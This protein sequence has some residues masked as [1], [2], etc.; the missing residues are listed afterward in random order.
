MQQNIGAIDVHFT[1]A[2]LAELNS[3][4]AAIKINGQRLP[5][6]VQV[7]SDSDAPPKR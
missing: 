7:F 2:E 5:D 3:S 1:A 6:A 4:V